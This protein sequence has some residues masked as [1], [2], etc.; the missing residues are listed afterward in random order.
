[1]ARD[2]G[3]RKVYFASAAPP[4]RFPNVYG[5]DMPAAKELIGFNRNEKQ[6]AEAI[7]A[8]WLVYQDIEDM[9]SATMHKNNNGIERFDA[10]CFNGDYVTGDIDQE[11]LDLL[12]KLRSDKAKTKRNLYDNEVIDIHN[13]D[14]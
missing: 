1:M 10:S 8:D 11:Y 4:V 3:A 13:D 5:I 7:G 12:Q 6:I 9:I 2:S 14:R